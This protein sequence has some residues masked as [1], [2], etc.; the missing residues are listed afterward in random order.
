MRKNEKKIVACGKYINL[1]ACNGWEYADR[2]N[3]SGI[4]AIIAVTAD[5]KLVLT[6]QYR[7][8]VAQR[9][10]EIPA[11]LAGDKPGN[12][13][14][15]LEAAAGRELLEETGYIAETFTY[16]AHGP[17]SAGSTS[18]VVTLF[19]AS[20]IR[21]ESEG[22]GDGSENI[23]VHEVPLASAGQWLQAKAADGILIDPKVYAALYL[24][25]AADFT[26]AE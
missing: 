2:I 9:T 24:A 13:S 4:V 6:E 10:I 22:G 23:F 14:E 26:D 19:K 25:G 7:I 17:L 5:G 21:K 20:G 18:E 12:R 1:V 8:P 11:G 16:L 15:S 3:L